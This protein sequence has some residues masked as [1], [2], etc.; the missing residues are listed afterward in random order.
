MRVIV[1]TGKKQDGIIALS[2][3]REPP[4]KKKK[5]EEKEEKKEQQ[6]RRRTRRRIRSGGLGVYHACVNGMVIE[7]RLGNIE[8]GDRVVDL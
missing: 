1:V 7:L 3:I 2:I 5:E 4:K 8:G 6:M